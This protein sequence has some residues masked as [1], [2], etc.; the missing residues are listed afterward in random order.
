MASPIEVKVSL[1]KNNNIWSARG[2][3][4]D[5]ITGIRKRPSKSLELKASEHTKRKALAMLPRIKAQWENELAQEV[6]VN[7]NPL[8][9]D[10]VM[11][12]LDT[13]SKT[14]KDNSMSGYRSYAKNHIIPV[15]GKFKT[16]DITYR[17]LQWYC[18]TMA[19]TL[20]PETI[21]KHFALINGVLSDAMRDGI[22]TSNP[23]K[24]VVLPR[25]KAKFRGTALNA[26]Q[27]KRLL[28]VAMADGE[29]MASV[30]M[31]AVVYGLRR[32]EICGLRWCDIDFDA[33]TMHIC[34][35]VVKS[36]NGYIEEE[37]TKTAKSDR[38]IALIDFTVPYLKGLKD[39]QC[40]NGLMLSKVCRWPN[41]DSVKHDYISHKFIKML[42]AN[43]LPK[44]RFHDLRH[45]AAT[46]LISS[47]ATP[48]QAQ[49]FLGH[50]SITT[51][52]NIYNH[53]LNESKLK[54]SNLLNLLYFS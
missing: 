15:L 52:M 23:A 46:L 1:W 11:K 20:K 45:T 48:Q 5:P 25:T 27:A 33:N 39:S 2:D 51:T 34:N 9:K 37:C 24:L 40:N 42:K 26:A 19:E 29:P 3:Y 13:K 36:D 16:K 41:G 43:D 31:L 32:S 38:V 6:V 21:R 12:W 35:T 22:I 7:Y 53:C 30:I 47:G 54:T 18:D 8:F 10:S 4:I 49:E 28:G 14:V 44:I 50:E 17:R